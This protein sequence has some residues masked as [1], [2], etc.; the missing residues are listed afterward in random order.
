MGQGGQISQRLLRTKT[1]SMLVASARS[2]EAP[3]QYANYGILGMVSTA[4]ENV[5]KTAQ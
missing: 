2:F 3:I 4:M 1:H 5:I